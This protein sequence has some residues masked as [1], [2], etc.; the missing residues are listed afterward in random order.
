MNYMRVFV[1]GK[2]KLLFSVEEVNC[3]VPHL[4]CDGIRLGGLLHGT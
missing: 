3:A 1:T 4:T 2:G